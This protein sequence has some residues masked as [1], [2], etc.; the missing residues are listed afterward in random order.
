VLTYTRNVSGTYLEEDWP[1]LEVGRNRKEGKTL[2]EGWPTCTGRRANL[3]WK[4]GQPLLE[5]GQTSIGRRANLYWNGRRANL[6]WKEGKPLLEGGQTS[7]GRRAN[8]Y[9]KEGKP[10]EKY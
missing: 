4:D 5:G 3:Y 1:F 7:T 9:W 2:L 8:L 10:T 6:C